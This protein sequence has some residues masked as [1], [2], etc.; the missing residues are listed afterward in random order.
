[1]VWTRVGI[2]VSV[3]LVVVGGCIDLEVNAPDTLLP[4]G[5]SFVVS[6]TAAVIDNDGSC[7]IWT[8]DNGVTYHLFQ[9]S[10]L[11]NELFDRVTTPGTRSRLELARRTDLQ[12]ACQTRGV[13]VEVQDVLEVVE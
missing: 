10:R 2:A 6:G 11:D 9:D 3:L 5:A 1:M 7:L 13:I 8:G 12:V 4:M